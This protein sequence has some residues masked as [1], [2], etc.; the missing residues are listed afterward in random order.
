MADDFGKVLKF[1]TVDNYDSS[2]RLPGQRNYTFTKGGGLILRIGGISWFEH[3][4]GDQVDAALMVNGMWSEEIW[5]PCCIW[6]NKIVPVQYREWAVFRRD[7][8]GF[9]DK[10]EYQ[11]PVIK[12]RVH[13]AVTYDNTRPKEDR[14]GPITKEH[15]LAHKDQRPAWNEW[16]PFFHK[17]LSRRGSNY[18]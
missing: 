17:L 10:L 2:S 13:K 7:I 4:A 3:H 18:A 11:W 8:Q 5:L 12:D 1:R 15:P 6:L 14:K 9:P 16:H